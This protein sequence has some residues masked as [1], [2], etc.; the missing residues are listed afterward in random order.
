GLQVFERFAAT[1]LP[2]GK[3]G[4][5]AADEGN[6]LRMFIDSGL[7]GLLGYSQIKV[8]GALGLEQGLP[9]LRTHIPVSLQ[10]IH[11]GTGDTALQVPLDVLD[12]L[13]LLAVDIPRNVEV[14]VVLLD[15]LDTDHAGIFGNLQPF[16]ENINDLVEV[17]VAQTIL[18]A[19][20]EVAAAGINHEDALAGVG[21]FLVDD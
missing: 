13:G 11:V 20:F 4:I 6:E 21:V 5:H 12:I 8:A 1:L 18:V 3:Q 15:L 7:Y 19:I 10:R 17:A 14:E 9:Q 2:V 16:V